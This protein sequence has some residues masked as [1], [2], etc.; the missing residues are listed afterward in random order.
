MMVPYGQ[1]WRLL[2]TFNAGFTYAYGGNGSIDN[3]R[4][5]EPLKAGIATLVG[6]RDGGSRS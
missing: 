5:N 2:A 1:R 3:G 4:V 6:Y